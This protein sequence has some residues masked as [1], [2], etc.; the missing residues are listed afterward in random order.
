MLLMD[1][2][3]VKLALPEI[4]SVTAGTPL[5]RLI[6]GVSGFPSSRSDQEIFCHLAAE[7]RDLVRGMRQGGAH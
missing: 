2:E 5:L 7:K 3:T 4:S 1:L 6:R